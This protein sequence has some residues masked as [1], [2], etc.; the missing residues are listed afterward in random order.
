MLGE[1]AC[2]TP[3]PGQTLPASDTDDLEYEYEPGIS[4]SNLEF[5]RSV[6]IQASDL[7]TVFARTK[8]PFCGSDYESG[9]TRSTFNDPLIANIEIKS[10]MVLNKSIKMLLFKLLFGSAAMTVITT[11]DDC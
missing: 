9:R 7:A 6:D 11:L 5:G 8:C 4:L 2:S 1:S 3:D 10:L